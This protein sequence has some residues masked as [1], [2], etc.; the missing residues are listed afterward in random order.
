MA[1]VWG[2]CAAWFFEEEGE[3]RVRE[4]SLR[5]ASQL[6]QTFPLPGGDYRKSVRRVIGGDRGQSFDQ[7]LPP[8][9]E[10]FQEF[11]G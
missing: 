7:G 4:R 1:M 11:R 5:A 8:G 3:R 2:V 9:R 10:P 6:Q